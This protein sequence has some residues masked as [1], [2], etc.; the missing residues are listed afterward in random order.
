MLVIIAKGIWIYQGGLTPWFSD[1]DADEDGDYD[2]DNANGD[3]SRVPRGV[4]S[5]KCHGNLT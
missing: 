5:R 1:Q 4:G 2:A 3:E